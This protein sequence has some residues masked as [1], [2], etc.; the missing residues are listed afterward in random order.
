M[1]QALKHFT[2]AQ[3]EAFISGDEDNLI[4]ILEEAVAQAKRAP[5]G[6]ATVQF[7]VDYEPEEEETEEGEE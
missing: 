6:V 7:F 3:I 5:D 2:T 1:P 4:S